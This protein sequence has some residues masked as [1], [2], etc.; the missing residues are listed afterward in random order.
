MAEQRLSQLADQLWPY[1]ARRVAAG[2]GGGS[3]G[4]SFTPSAH[5]ALTGLLGDDHPQYLRTDGARTLTGNLAVASGITIDGIDIS[6]HAGD[7]AAHHEP[8][9]AG[10]GIAVTGQQ[11]ALANGTQQYQVQVT[12]TSPFAPSWTALASLAGNGLTFTN[13]Q[14]AVGVTN[15]GAAGLSVEADQIRLT[16]SNNPGAAA[17]I[18]ATNVAG[19]LT[20]VQLTLSERLRASL[21][22]TA[23]GDLALSPAS[24]ITT[25]SSLHASTRVRTPLLDTAAGNMTVSPAAD[26]TLS[27]GSNLVRLAAGRVLQSDNYASQTTGMRISYAGE[28]D[29]RYLF[30]DE[31]HAKSFIAD[32]E[33]A[34]AGGQIIS[35]SVAVL[36]ADF[37]LPGAGSAATLQVRDLPSAPNM[38]VFQSGDYV[39]LRQF[40]R[41]G[42]SLTIG[43]A[44]GTVTNYADQPDGTQTWTFTRHATT[45]GSASGT[46][47]AD[48][49]VLDF[50]VS[51]NGFYEVNAIDGLYAA[52]SP[53]AQIVT[54]QTHP[55]TQSV[56]TRFGNLR[57]ITNVDGEF[58]LFAGS[59]TAVTDRYVRASSS[60]VELR[61]VPLA[62][63]DGANNTALLS[64][65]ANNNAPFF[66]MGSP[67]PTA[68]LTNSGVWM[69]LAG[70]AYQFRVG[71]ISNGQLAQGIHWDGSNLTVRGTIV[72]TGSFSGVN[73]AGAA[74]PGGAANSIVNQGALATANSAS[75]TTQVSNRPTELTDGRITTA[76]NSTGVV[77]SRIDPNTNWGAN[78]G[79]GLAG[80]LLGGD[81]M[82]YWTGTAWRTY[83]DNAGRFYVNAGAGSNFLSWD[84]AT[85]TVSG[86]I[87][88]VGGNAATT[89]YVDTTAAG[90]ANTSLN[91]SAISTLIN[92]NSIRVGS[93]TK[94]SNLNG[95]NIDSEEIVGQAA[96]VDQVV[97]NTSGQIVAGQG[98]VQ[99]SSTGIGVA[100]SASTL[101][102]RNG[103]RL[104]SSDLSRVLGGIYGYM[105]SNTD[106]IEMNVYSAT[107]RHAGMLTVV[108]APSSQTA[109]WMLVVRND[110]YNYS[111]TVSTQYGLS[112]T[113]N[114]FVTGRFD[115]SGVLGSDWSNVAFSSGWSNY[116]NGYHSCQYRRFGDRISLRGLAYS[117]STNTIV[118]TLP[119][120][121][122]PSARRLFWVW[123]YVPGSGLTSRRIDILTTGEIQT[124]DWTPNNGSLFSFDEISFS[125]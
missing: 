23:L 114:T 5:G 25:L 85:L 43:W 104:L 125:L 57:G 101:I 32:L 102:E 98:A 17:S 63:F 18:L 96:G 86:A 71:S 34:L 80:L 110:I 97:L 117:S 115:V 33:Q 54:W 109:D 12:G 111:L 10:N 37:A 31:L 16:S 44:W 121:Y 61:N 89:T 50:G 69:G 47:A 64:A 46:I 74:T 4:I 19:L 48:S 116:G 70:G 123:S 28:G 68:P 60:A 59:G 92:G 94:D 14:F 100:S 40:S 58:G 108:D 29:F 36:A 7:P 120:G 79:A 95:W 55:A 11:V 73:Y 39:G 119:S 51:G 107:G 66:A 62:L 81:Y 41:S 24:G 20:L 105:G 118:T 99:L 15:T 90:K 67:L 106:K 38:A 76:I 72:V 53:Y 103:Y 56:R 13:G 124:V 91:N 82:G 45:P 2:N 35:K 26:L 93:G 6:A 1:L 75:W 78:P 42:G 3:S 84:G 112:L 21:I 113:G 22:D 27:P 9:T 83:M 30:T 52:N 49:I 65:G 77:I 88:V 87:N 122:R 8:V